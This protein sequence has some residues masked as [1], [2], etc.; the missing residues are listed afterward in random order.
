[1][2]Y[3]LYII[4]STL[5]VGGIFYGTRQLVKR[6]NRKKLTD[7]VAALLPADDTFD[8][9]MCLMQS[10]GSTIVSSRGVVVTGTPLVKNPKQTPCGQQY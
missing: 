5:I 3:I 7:P 10:D 2:D 1:M 4:F 9:F 8:D 6:I